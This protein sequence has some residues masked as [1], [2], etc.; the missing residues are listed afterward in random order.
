M[1]SNCIACGSMKQCKDLY[2]LCTKEKIYDPD[3]GEDSVKVI[4]SAPDGTEYNQD[5]H[6]ENILLKG[7]I[8][9][10]KNI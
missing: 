2:D 5:A 4:S 10:I 6:V 3:N 9:G 8:R 7:I 1:V